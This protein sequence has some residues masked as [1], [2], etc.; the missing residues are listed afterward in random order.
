MAQAIAALSARAIIGIRQAA[1]L[2]QQE[3]QQFETA[4]W[5]HI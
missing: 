4:R 5:I 2:G 3:Q 1:E